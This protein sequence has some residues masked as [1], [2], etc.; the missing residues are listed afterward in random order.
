MTDNLPKILVVDDEIA[1]LEVMEGYLSNDYEIAVASSG[2]EALEK[3]PQFQPDVILL[4]ILMPV[5]D[6]FQTCKAM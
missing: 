5:M 6:G 4:D 3:V 2:K 1:N